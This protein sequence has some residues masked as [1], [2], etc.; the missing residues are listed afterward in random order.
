MKVTGVPKRTT[1]SPTRRISFNTPERVRTSDEAAPYSH[2]QYSQRRTRIRDEREFGRT[3]R[4]TTAQLRAK[5]VEAFKR[6]RG[7]PTTSRTS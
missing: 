6:R 5:A 2:A 3:M 1:E 4:K 7:R